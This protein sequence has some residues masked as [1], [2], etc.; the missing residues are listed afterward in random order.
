MVFLQTE[1]YT[2]IPVLETL[3]YQPDYIAIIFSL[4]GIIHYK[5][6]NELFTEWRSNNIRMLL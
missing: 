4:S 2:D 6:E 5:L 1:T 3:G